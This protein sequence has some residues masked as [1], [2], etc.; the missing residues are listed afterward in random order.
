MKTSDLILATFL[1]CHFVSF[2]QSQTD[3]SIKIIQ[4]Q[5]AVVSGGKSKRIEH[6]KT[7]GYPSY[8]S[9]QKNDKY[10]NLIAGYPKGK[11]SYVEF[12]F[13]TGLP[14]MFK[15]KLHIDYQDVDLKLLLYEVIDSSEIGEPLIMPE[16]KFT[17]SKDHNGSYR[18]PLSQFNIR[19]DRIFIGFAVVSETTKGKSNIYVRMN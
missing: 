4:L 5:E 15:N 2:G 11:I 13:N 16:I 9:F 12:F 10:I 3:T 17:V 6:F 8:R 14:N 1:L 7:T 18:I 19:E